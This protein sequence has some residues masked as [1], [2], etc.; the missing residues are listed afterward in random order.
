MRQEARP[1][2]FHD[3]HAGALRR[4]EHLP[5][6]GGVARECLLD[7]DVLARLDGEQCVV[8]VRAVWR[9]D[10]HDVDV[11]VSNEFAV[12][13]VGRCSG[14]EFV[15]ELLRP[16]NISRTDGYDALR[17]PRRERLRERAGDAAGRDDAPAQARCVHGVEGAWLR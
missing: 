1:H 12:G 8:A 5:S 16:L 3:E 10:V 7:E 2:G 11:V 4:L 17:R 15:D 13:S 9:G 6:L 14:G